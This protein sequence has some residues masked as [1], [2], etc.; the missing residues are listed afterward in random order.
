MEATKDRTSCDLQG[1]ESKEYD[2][3]L[4]LDRYQKAISTEEKDYHKSGSVLNVLEGA[5]N[6]K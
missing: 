1:Y 3:K 6:G 2:A 4:C 5:G